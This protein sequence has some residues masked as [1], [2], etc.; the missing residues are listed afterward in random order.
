V[1]LTSVDH[2][3]SSFQKKATIISD[4]N[5]ELSLDSDVLELSQSPP[6]HHLASQGGYSR[7]LSVGLA[8]AYVTQAMKQSFH[9]PSIIDCLV[10]MRRVRAY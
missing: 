1:F 8:K 10:T 5:V 2:D 4:H 3:R 9:S 6:C 7:S